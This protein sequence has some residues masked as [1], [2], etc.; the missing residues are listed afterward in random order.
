[1]EFLKTLFLYY[2]M[3][4]GPDDGGMEKRTIIIAMFFLSCLEQVKTLNEI[5]KAEM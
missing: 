4:D 5:M 3:A 1:M 2:Y